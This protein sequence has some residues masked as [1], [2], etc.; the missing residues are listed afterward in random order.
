MTCEQYQEL[1]YQQA[2]GL[3]G[4]E[5]AAYLEAHLAACA[6]CGRLARELAAINAALSE[7]P[8]EEPP[9]ALARAVSARVLATSRRQPSR[10]AVPLWPRLTPAAVA[11]ATVLACFAWL[12]L[13]GAD[14]RATVT[15]LPGSPVQ[16]LHAAQSAYWEALHA[17]EAISRNGATWWAEATSS[18][19]EVTAAASHRLPRELLYS[20]LILL[21]L[22]NGLLYVRRPAEARLAESW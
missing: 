14:A 6:S 2:D 7:M 9:P 4:P 8:R 12:W 11:F 5:Q 1:V 16:A 3:L 17:P 19:R 10:P 22:A 21:M 20:A 13:L 18:L 15:I